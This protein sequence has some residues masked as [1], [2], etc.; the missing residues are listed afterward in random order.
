MGERNR[1]HVT[2]EETLNGRNERLPRGSCSGLFSPA[3]EVQAGARL[4]L[5]GDAED[6]YKG[7]GHPC[8]RAEGLGRAFLLAPSPAAPAP[9]RPH[10][11]RERL[12]ATP[13][14][15]FCRERRGGVWIGDPS[16]SPA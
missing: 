3:E 4:P 15:G 5:P 2:Q 10:S 11:P 16:A 12:P 9:R 14:L 1:L 6:T 7:A 13:Q 8:Q